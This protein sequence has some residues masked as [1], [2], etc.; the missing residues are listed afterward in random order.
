MAVRVTVQIINP[1]RIISTEALA[2]VDI[3]F[4]GLIICTVTLTAMCYLFYYTEQ[5]CLNIYLTRNKKALVP[6]SY[7]LGYYYRNV[8]LYQLFN[9]L[10]LTFI[11][12][13]N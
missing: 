10:I 9:C 7:F 5:N 4:Q 8:P 1:R 6:L 2:E 3:I 13:S 11:W 12:G